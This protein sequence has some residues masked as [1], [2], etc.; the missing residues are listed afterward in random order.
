MGAGKLNVFAAQA[1]YELMGDG[2]T[3]CLT[4]AAEQLADRL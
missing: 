4:L 2:S 1:D 3:V